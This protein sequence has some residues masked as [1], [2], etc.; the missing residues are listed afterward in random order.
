MLKGEQRS[1]STVRISYLSIS[2]RVALQPVR[3]AAAAT[4]R[5]APASMTS[6]NSRR[7]KSEMKREMPT[8]RLAFVRNPINGNSIP[9]AH[10]ERRNE[11]LSDFLSCE[12]SMRTSL[13][14]FG[15]S[16]VVRSATTRFVLRR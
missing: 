7:D 15:R 14:C 11:F 8:L 10:T 3:S 9:V 4:F 16:Q 12:N 6:T 1:S 2:L 13:S 5:L